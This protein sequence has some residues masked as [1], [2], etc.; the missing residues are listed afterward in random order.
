MAFD[1]SAQRWVPDGRLGA[2]RPVTDPRAGSEPV[3]R[4][5]PDPR[6]A[7]PYR[8]AAGRSRLPTSCRTPARGPPSSR[9]LLAW[10]AHPAAAPTPHVR[11]CRGD[12]GGLNLSLSGAARL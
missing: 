2:V 3:L 9:R 10:A 8:S 5:G 1:V 12:L 4:R 7:R 6:S 11:S